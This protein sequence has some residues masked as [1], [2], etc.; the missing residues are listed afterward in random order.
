MTLPASF[1]ERPIAHRG[2]HDKAAGRPENSMEAFRAAIEHG[3]GIELDLQLSQDGVAMVFHDYEL[4][5]LTDEKGPVAL[6]SA[7]ELT[8]IPL[9]HGQEPIPTLEQVLDLVAGRVPLLIETKDQDGA[10]GQNVGPLEKATTDLLTQ[11]QGDVA[12]MSFNPHSVA[13]K[14]DTAPQIPRGIVTS[15]YLPED[16]PTIPE[17][18]RDRLRGIPDVGRVEASFISHEANDLTSKRVAEIRSSGLNVLC[19]TI[20]SKADEKSA[21][22]YTDNVTFE[23]YEA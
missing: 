19:W 21:L 22:K 16:W 18:T 6:R 23:G 15:S 10:L 1:L 9:R 11:Y 14:R 12:V 5:R 20:R 4:S 17:G 13:A 7:A 3:Y 2:Y 8:Q